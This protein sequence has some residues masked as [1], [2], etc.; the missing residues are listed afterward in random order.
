MKNKDCLIRSRGFSCPRRQRV[1]HEVLRT[2]RSSIVQM[3][4]HMACA[5]ATRNTVGETAD[6]NDEWKRHHCPEYRRKRS[7]VLRT[8]TQCRRILRWVAVRKRKA[9][10]KKARSADTQKKKGQ[11][12]RTRR[13]E[14]DRG[15]N[16]DSGHLKTTTS[17]TQ[18]GKRIPVHGLSSLRCLRRRCSANS[19]QRNSGKLLLAGPLGPRPL[20]PSF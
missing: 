7:A 5:S 6:C 1:L 4:S 20:S 8:P 17:N 3:S 19:R 15:A 14:T 13:Q 12:T 9:A 2:T 16:S 18:G 11:K 10:R